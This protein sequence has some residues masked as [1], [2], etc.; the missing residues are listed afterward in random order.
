MPR[1]ATT[2]RFGSRF[3]SL[4]VCLPVSPA[5][6][7][8]LFA[9]TW[10]TTVQSATAST[11]AYPTTASTADARPGTTSSE[12][13]PRPPQPHPTITLR[14]A[15]P[16]SDVIEVVA[17]YP[18]AADTIGMY[19]QSAADLP[20][21]SADL[22]EDLRVATT[23]GRA[24][25]IEPLGGGDWRLVDRPG[26]E[27][28]ALS[29]RIRLDHDEHRW[30][31][32]IDEVAYRTGDG[33]FFSGRSLFVVPLGDPLDEGVEI[34]FDLPAGW[35][36]SHPWSAIGT[37]NG[38]RAH[39]LD[40]DD[41]VVNCL[42]LGTHFEETVALGDFEFVLALGN[43]V[44]GQ[45]DLIVRTM[46]PTLLAAREVFGG[47]PARTRFLAVINP[48][49]R[50]DG[51]AFLSS[52]SMLLDGGVDAT[53]A[54][55]WG[56]GVVH[57]LLHFWNGKRLTP[58]DHR[59]EWFREGLT[60]YLTVVLRAREEQDPP[61]MTRR[62]LENAAR[63]QIL[64]RMMMGVTAPLDEAGAQ[65]QRNRML[66][67]GGGLLAAFALD[68]EIREATGDTKSL[69]DL[70]RALYADFALRDRMYTQE[71][72]RTMANRVAGADL[73]AFFDQHVQ[74]STMIDLGALAPKVGMR[75]TTMLDEFYLS[76]DPDATE[77]VLARREA[78][79]G[80]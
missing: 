17:H 75:L 61:E 46:R 53:S 41:L 11:T 49:P 12:H 9:L 21:G 3:A 54:V 38:E 67:Y 56:H 42:F 72:L 65:K 32:G 28:L 37:G 4:P 73:S 10:P 77:A 23:S 78:V 30:G 74:G 15:T 48:Y 57:E 6:L 64:A 8:F 26:G 62:K 33:L 50:T 22:V 5:I 35:K 31:P 63:R 25:A 60:D 16:E 71:D 40:L 69:E 55:L 76:A 2:V 66:V 13:V 29:Y 43:A 36:A 24:L 1:P 20:N 18:A 44:A 59:G 52:Y 51:G 27:G 58:T 47:M 45:R 19:I 39:A 7:V 70:L 79:F 34:A 14:V 68:L 80:W